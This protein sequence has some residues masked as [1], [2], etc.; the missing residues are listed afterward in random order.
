M[1]SGHITGRRNRLL[2][3]CSKHVT[4]KANLHT[5]YILYTTY[6]MECVYQ[7]NVQINYS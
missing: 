7:V 3:Y 4:K 1:I 6:K 2:S 5:H